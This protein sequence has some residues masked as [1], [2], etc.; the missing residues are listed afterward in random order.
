MSHSEPML[1]PQLTESGHSL[2][3]LKLLLLL[4]LL[5]VWGSARQD[6]PRPTN[7]RPGS[8][9]PG[10][11]LPAP[12]TARHDPRKNIKDAMKIILID[13][14]QTLCKPCCCFIISLLWLQLSRLCY[15]MF[16]NLTIFAEP[17]LVCFSNKKSSRAGSL[18]AGVEP[19]GYNV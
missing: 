8:A 7:T 9:A 3:L 4:L 17:L 5:W 1:S 13:T 11:Q 18:P 10:P 6:G 2:M 19:N 12:A 15:S 16:A 14:R